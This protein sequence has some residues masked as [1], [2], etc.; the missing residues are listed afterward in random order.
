MQVPDSVIRADLI[1][2]TAEL[3][4]AV[5]SQGLRELLAQRGHDAMRSIQIACDQGDDVSI[6]LV[7]EDSSAV[8]LNYREHYRTRQA[9]RIV[10]WEPLRY[11]DRE[12]EMAKNLVT[13]CDNTFES[14]V[15]LYFDENMA[16]TDSL[17]PPLQWGDRMWHAFEQPPD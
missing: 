10:D 14:D 2:Q 17:L 1:E 7:L 4:Y 9:I 16:E 12:L 15:R 3:R 6:D 13:Q 5:A 11:S 8:R